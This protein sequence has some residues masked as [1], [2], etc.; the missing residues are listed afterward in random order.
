MAND[1]IPTNQQDAFLIPATYS[2]GRNPVKSYLDSL[3]AKS[4][5]TQMYSLKAIIALIFDVDMATI[6]DDAVYGF[7]WHELRYQHTI[8]IRTRLAEEYSHS[9]ANRSLS[10]LRRVLKECWRLGY[11]DNET[12]ARA[13]DIEN[14]K[15]QTV[16]KGRDVKSGEINALVDACYR[17]TNATIGVRDMAILGVLYTTGMRRNELASL[18]LADYTAD[19]NKLFIRKGKGNKERLVYVPDNVKDAIQEWLRF[20]GSEPGGLFVAVLKGGRISRKYKTIE[21]NGKK[22]KLLKG[23]AAQTIYD[24]LARRANESGVADFSPHDLRRTFVGDMLEKGVDISTVQKITGHANVSTTA[25]YDRRG[26]KAKSQAV[27]KLHF[28]YRKR[29]KLMDIPE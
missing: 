2:N 11:I 27:N 12:M 21:E 29:R 3:S 23:I 4:S 17:D 20:R 28:P 22:K 8:A 6:D 16:P 26:E 25:R 19:E 7:Q 10:A 9:S 18:E 14:V 5:E 15:G 13:C 24:M 1:I